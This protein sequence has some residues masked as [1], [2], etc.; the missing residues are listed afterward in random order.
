MGVGGTSFA[1]KPTVLSKTMS[2]RVQ[3]AQKLALQSSDQQIVVVAKFPADAACFD[4]FDRLVAPFGAYRVE[5]PSF[6]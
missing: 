6:Q 1:M 3:S 5:E 4:D 2:G